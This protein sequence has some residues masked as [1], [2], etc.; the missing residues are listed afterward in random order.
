MPFVVQRNGM[1]RFLDVGRALVRAKRQRPHP[2]V[3]ASSH[4]V[5]RK[6][7]RIHGVPKTDER[8]PGTCVRGIVVGRL[9]F[10]GPQQPVA[11]PPEP[12]HEPSGRIELLPVGTVGPF[13]PP[14]E[15]A[16]LD[17][18]HEPLA[19]DQ[20]DQHANRERTST[21]S[22]CVDRVSG[23]TAISTDIVLA[24]EPIETQ[25][26]SLESPANRAAKDGERRE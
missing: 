14:L 2:L 7:V 12:R 9:S 16:S 18:G 17:A 11:Q 10:Q 22:K 1:T 26:V 25:D 13:R 21:E 20:I 4:L 24:R 6:P 19:G 15:L 8:D 5:N 23:V 3:P